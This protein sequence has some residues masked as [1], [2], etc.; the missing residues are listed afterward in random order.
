M[1]EIIPMNGEEPEI[2]TPENTDF[3]NLNERI[4]VNEVSEIP[5]FPELDYDKLIDEFNDKEKLFTI[6]DMIDVW[7]RG[8]TNGATLWQ[9]CLDKIQEQEQN[10]MNGVACQDNNY[11]L[12][13]S[14]EAGALELVNEVRNS[15]DKAQALQAML[16][17]NMLLLGV[18]T[19]KQ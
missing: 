8:M 7:S 17:N 9:Y 6:D 15:K 10:T 16:N 1:S 13:S 2:P 12:P 19:E 5:T 3:Q 14:F 11:K 18:F 4:N